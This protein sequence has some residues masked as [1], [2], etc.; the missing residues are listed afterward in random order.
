MGHVRIQARQ[1]ILG[2]VRAW[3]KL[4]LILPLRN[5]VFW[6]FQRGTSPWPQSIL[7]GFG[8]GEGTWAIIVARYMFMQKWPTNIDTESVR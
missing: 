7:F 2:H 6:A 4:Y 8:A 5:S 3:P 1:N